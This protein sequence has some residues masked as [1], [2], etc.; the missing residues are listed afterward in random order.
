MVIAP[1]IDDTCD[2]AHWAGTRWAAY[3]I[4]CHS[5]GMASEQLVK[6]T[7]R[8]GVVGARVL[9]PA[10]ALA[11][12]RS[13]HI[14][15]F[16]DAGPT[17]EALA[18]CNTIIVLGVT[19]IG[20]EIFKDEHESP[21]RLH[22]LVDT[23]IDAA[24]QGNVQTVLLVDSALAYGAYANNPLPLTEDTLLRPNEGLGVAI[25]QAEA[26]RRLRGAHGLRDVRIVV[27]RCAPVVGRRPGSQMPWI[28]RTLLKER[29]V[30]PPVQLVH[31]DD[32]ASA[33]VHVLDKGLAGTFCVA[34][35]GWLA[36]VEADA[37]RRQRLRV[38]TTP[39]ALP[40][41]A[42]RRFRTRMHKLGLSQ[43]PP[44]LIPVMHYPVVVSNTRLRRTGWEPN[45]TNAQALL[46]A[47]DA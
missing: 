26:E 44:A 42:H 2:I 1:I 41:D 27:L 46:A 9:R 30:Q 29:G 3:P 22:D 18:T 10:L 37:I 25:D 14:G 35:N 6:A 43:I 39:V 19:D 36:P 21:L 33:I 32:V 45:W 5:Y 12:R 24:G 13:G 11:L 31:E 15:E 47:L 28:R 16:C 34:P 20:T 40:T 17:I 7:D 4:A 38:F 8:I 23:V